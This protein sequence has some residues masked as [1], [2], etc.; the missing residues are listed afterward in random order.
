MF[1]CLDKNNSKCR[2]VYNIC[3]SQT[4]NKIAQR[5]KGCK[6]NHSVLSHY[7]VREVL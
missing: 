6:W 5:D 1:E 7:S 3:R 2:G 4:H